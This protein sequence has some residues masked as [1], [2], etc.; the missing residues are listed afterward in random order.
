MAKT[1]ILLVGLKGSGK[2]YIGSLLSR[3]TDIRF[4][5]VEPIWL[6]LKEGEDGWAKV[7][8]AVDEV[9]AEY[10]RVAIES[11]GGS[12]GFERLRTALAR[13]YRVQ[14]VRIR[15]A[16]DTCLRR[17]QSRSTVD[18]LPVS[19]DKVA[20]YNEAALRVELPWDAEIDNEGPASDDE[21][22]GVF[23]TL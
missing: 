1:V 10:D 23:S 11:L 8:D 3:Q 7:A 4:L 18:H 13:R 20:E 5:R 6:A 21:I 22:L 14:Y 15:T 16:P 9:L 17:V 2:T 19:D 12:E